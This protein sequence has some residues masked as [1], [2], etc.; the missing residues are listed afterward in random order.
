MCL[1]SSLLTKRLLQ[2]VHL[3]LSTI[4]QI[5]PSRMYDPQD[6]VVTL[7]KRDMRF[8]FGGEWMKGHIGTIGIGQQGAFVEVG[9]GRG[10]EG[11]CGR[12]LMKLLGIYHFDMRLSLWRCGCR[13]ERWSETMFVD[14]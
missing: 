6:G 8:F 7:D 9:G 14:C 5:L 12:K 13:I 11:K 4:A 1:Y 2:L 3:V 10:R